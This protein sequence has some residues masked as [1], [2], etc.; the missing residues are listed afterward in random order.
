L[1]ARETAER[2]AKDVVAGNGE[3]LMGDF[4]G[5]AFDDLMSCS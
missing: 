5:T 1:S 4:S 2:Y 3:R